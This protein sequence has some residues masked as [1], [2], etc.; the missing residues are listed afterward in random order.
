[1]LYNL[2]SY[3]CGCNPSQPNNIQNIN[4]DELD[5]DF[6]DYIDDS[7]QN[8][9]GYT[10][11]IFDCDESTIGKAQLFLNNRKITECVQGSKNTIHIPQDIYTIKII[12]NN[13]THEDINI[14]LNISD[15]F[16]IRVEGHKIYYQII[17]NE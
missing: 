13:F 17:D 4:K 5:D 10:T 3:I 14:P 15:I 12:G 11:L 8:I 7:Y 9:S 1:M 6:K 16:I 2:I